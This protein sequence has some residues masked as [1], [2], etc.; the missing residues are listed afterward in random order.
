MELNNCSISVKANQFTT[1]T[2][3]EMEFCNPTEREIEGLYQFELQPHQVITAFQLE[4]NGKYR[5][6][7]IEEKWKATNTYNAIV[8]KRIDPAL[9]TMDYPGHYRLRIY[10]VPAKGCRRI[11]MTI[12]ELLMTDND[13]L[14]YWLPLNIINP[15]RQFN[16]DVSVVGNVRPFV[17]AGLLM[18]RDFVVEDNEQTIRWRAQDVSLKLPLSFTIPV[19]SGVVGVKS[20]GRQT[21]FAT[22]FKPQI[23]KD[24]T[25]RPRTLTV[26]WDASASLAKRDVKREINFLKQ[27][28]SYH[29]VAQ[30]TIIP[31][32]HKLLDTAVFYTENGFNSRW[33]QYLEDMIYDG[34]TQLGI[35]DATRNE[36]NMYLLFSDGNNTFGS[37]KPKIGTALISCINTSPGA[38][39]KALQQIAGSGGGKVINLNMMNVNSAIM[40]ASR[41][42]NWLMNISSS[43]GKVINEQALPLTQEPVMLFNG[44]MQPGI[45]TLFF[46]FGNNDHINHIEKIIIDSR[47]DTVSDIDRITMLKE[48]VKTIRDFSWSNLVDFG[49]KE[50]VVTPYTAY[51]V[52]EQLEDYVKYNIDPPDDLKAECEKMNYVKRD[53][54]FERM[55]AEK[56]SEFD[57]LQGVVNAYNERIRKWDS[58][59]QLVYLD[60][61]EIEKIGNLENAG[62]SMKSLRTETKDV[63]TGPAQG[64]DVSNT[65][66]QE[67]VVIGYGTVRRS[68]LT[69]SVSVVR[70]RE[71]FSSGGSVEQLLQGRVSGLQVTAT[72]AAPGSSANIILRGTS[73]SNNKQ[74]LFVVDG[75]PLK[76]NINDFLN[77]NDIESITVLKDL[78]ATALY[79]S[80][81]SGG[82]IIITTKKARRY[83]NNYDKRS[84]RLKDMDDVEYIQVLKDA[85]KSQEKY[86]Y[87]RLKVEYGDEPGF[88]FDAAQYFFEIGLTEH[89]HEILMNAIEAT[90]GIGEGLVAAAYV[91]EGWRCY[92][93][94][95]QIYEQLVKNS[96]TNLRYWDNLAWAYYQ[97]GNYQR[98]VDVLNDAIKIN[99][100]QQGYAVTYLKAMLMNDMNAIIS[101]H[102]DKLDIKQIP[103]AL[104]RPLPVDMRIV[105]DCNWV[106]PGNVTISEP[107]NY[108]C[109]FLNPVTKN[110]GTIQSGVYH[111]YDRPFEY[112]IKHSR[113]GKYKISVNYYDYHSNLGIPSII[114][115]RT[116]KNFGKENQSIEVENVV[117]DNQNGEIEIAEVIWNEK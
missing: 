113:P 117:T 91:L 66:M 64:L 10:P 22:R 25:L 34:A 9:L 76:G 33:Q 18:G 86:V 30:L 77:V 5:D 28:I 110:G 82:A 57:I 32:N 111:Y 105:I 27:F 94:A 103:G 71:I 115:I 48:F 11:T 42:E 8:G 80:R 81:A 112:G 52:L 97:T 75:V 84:Y 107:G 70:P 61:A 90:N 54:R 14:S 50:R 78:N 39:L 83:H 51:L 4:L 29:N 74:P 73:S 35:V 114:R 19:T 87:D 68:Q 12:R 63:L 62:I 37:S 43:S 44:K 95:L 31:F 101:L 100:G 15:V 13:E 102:K 104:I 45:D 26:F 3:I 96:P 65:A 98:A 1:T 106:Y 88:Y 24:Y 79:G 56:A 58:N 17:K 2:F 21:Y 92:R 6:G 23:P 55:R 20:D 109:S 60:R 36:S 69:G 47:H 72:P 49:L 89:A 53:T 16:L 108:K 41:G 59:E 46:Q 40:A 116:F 7:S 99:T 85:S 67:V 93:D 38:N